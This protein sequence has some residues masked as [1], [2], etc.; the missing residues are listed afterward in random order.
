M[1]SPMGIWHLMPA[2]V[3]AEGGE[4]SEAGGGER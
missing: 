4:R 2:D 3:C 1:G